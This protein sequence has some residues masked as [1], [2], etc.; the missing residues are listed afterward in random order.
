MKHY[1]IDGNN[2]IHKIKTLSKLVNKD[3]QSPREKLIFMIEAY[4]QGRKAKITIHYDGFER[5]P[6][7]T[8]FIKIVYSDKKTADDKIK[9]QIEAEENRRNLVVITSD[10]GIKAFARKCECEV[11]SS[12]DF[13]KQLQSRGKVDEEAAR[14]NSMNNNEYFKKIFKAGKS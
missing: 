13:I 11:I 4:F 14:I 6:I 12:E 9:Y 7:R 8:S 3:K 1:I 2:V 5:L 10:A